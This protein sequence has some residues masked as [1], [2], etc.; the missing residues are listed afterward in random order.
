MTAIQGSVCHCVS[1]L[2]RF[3]TNIP[4]D[5][6]PESLSSI[7]WIYSP[8]VGSLSSMEMLKSEVLRSTSVR[9]RKRTNPLRQLQECP[10]RNWKVSPVEPQIWVKPKMYG[11]VTGVR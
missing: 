9:N 1:A 7:L 5:V 10:R 3:S 6:E 2:K 11:M 4:N 8:A